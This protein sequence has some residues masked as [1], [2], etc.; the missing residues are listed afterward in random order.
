MTYDYQT[1]VKTVINACKSHR[2]TQIQIDN[3]YKKIS[4]IL[5]E[6][7][8]NENIIFS[9]YIHLPRPLANTKKSS[10]AI[11]NTGWVFV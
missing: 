11:R 10:L 5:L 9:K 8:G 6:V 3:F 1:P 4:F 7:Y 2:W